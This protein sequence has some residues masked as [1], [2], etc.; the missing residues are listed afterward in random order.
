M[1]IYR[2]Q[3]FERMNFQIY[4][5][6]GFSGIHAFMRFIVKI[7]QVGAVCIGQSFVTTVVS[8]HLLKFKQMQYIF[9]VNF[10]IL[11]IKQWYQ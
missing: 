3:R 10:R 5:E 9:A 2:I 8:E 11:I 6:N 7:I 1:Y 4:T